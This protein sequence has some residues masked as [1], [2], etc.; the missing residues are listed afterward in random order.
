[1]RPDRADV[2]QPARGA[3]TNPR[4]VTGHRESKRGLDDTLSPRFC[5][6]F[7]PGLEQG[8][9]DVLTQVAALI[10]C[11][12]SIAPHESSNPEAGASPA[13][14][15]RDKAASRLQSNVTQDR[16][17]RHAPC[18]SGQGPIFLVKSGA[19]FEEVTPWVK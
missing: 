5:S 4:T 11:M 10:T 19:A 14:I 17:F 2:L 12:F 9:G 8:G 15:S 6:R 16:D 18:Q 13:A 7:E 1:M 3:T